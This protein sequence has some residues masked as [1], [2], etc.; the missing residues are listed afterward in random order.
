MKKIHSAGWLLLI[1]GATTFVLS[2]CG[3]QPTTLPVVYSVPLLEY[4]LLL[5]YNDVFWCDPD[6]YPIT[7]EGQEQ[8]NAIAQF[9]AIEVDTAEFSA[10]LQ[11]LEMPEQTD[12][13]DTQKLLIY[14]EYKKLTYAVEIT[15][16]SSPYDFE[17]R[18]GEGQGALIK[19]TITA[20]GQITQTSSEPSVNTCPICLVKGTLIDTPDGPVPVEELQKGMTV[21]TVDASGQRLPATLVA[22]SRTRVP[23]FLQVVRVVL[24][25]GRSV[26]A[27]PGH[28]AADGRSLGGIRVGDTLDGAAVVAADLVAYDGGATFDLLPA[29]E[30]GLYFANGILLKSTLSLP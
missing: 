10:I 21:W 27:S 16:S 17:L 14:R 13:T 8:A 7:R 30:T 9:P 25:D 1:I 22:T 4:R 20:S 19:G 6:L 28:P 12:Y 23:T 24:S 15:G 26:T 18:I 11:H 29:G 5:E 3:K 2:G